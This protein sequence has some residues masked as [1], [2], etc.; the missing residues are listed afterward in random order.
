MTKLSLYSLAALAV[1][2]ALGCGGCSARNPEAEKP[3]NQPAPVAA[4]ASAEDEAMNAQL[5]QNAQ[6]LSALAMLQLTTAMLP[7]V[8]A[9]EPAPPPAATPASLPSML[10]LSGPG[11]SQPGATTPTAGE[12]PPTV[13]NNYY[14]QQVVAAEPAADVP[15]AEAPPQVVYV[16]G[17]LFV[18]NRGGP[19]PV[20][21]PPTAQSPAAPSG[22]FYSTVSQVARALPLDSGT[23]V[24]RGSTIT[25][26]NT[27]GPLPSLPLPVGTPVT[28]STSTPQRG[29]RGGAAGGG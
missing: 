20:A 11:V 29:G 18:P 10:P 4:V 23:M 15:L 8:M 26:R 25:V 2:L 27:T 21:P 22:P 13:V 17:G 7:P 14:V 5:L 9:A 19:A 6:L 24:A 16:S 28:T 1:T 3:V 12:I